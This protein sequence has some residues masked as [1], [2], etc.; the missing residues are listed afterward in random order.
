MRIFTELN[1]KEEC[2]IE[3]DQEYYIYLKFTN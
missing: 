2:F 1:E 3:Y